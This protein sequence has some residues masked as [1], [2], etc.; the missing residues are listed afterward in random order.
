MIHLWGYCGRDWNL[1]A[2]AIFFSHQRLLAYLAMA[3]GSSE[4]FMGL[5]FEKMHPRTALCLNPR[6]PDGLYPV[7]SAIIC[8]YLTVKFVVADPKIIPSLSAT[9]LTIYVP[10]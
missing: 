7:F 10:F 5:C 1:R 4:I 8:G 3:G 9:A 2:A 6:V